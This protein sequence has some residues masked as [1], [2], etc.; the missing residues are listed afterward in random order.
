MIQRIGNI[1]LIII[2]LCATT[3]MVV[4]KHYMH[5]ELYSTAIFSN[6][7]SCCIDDTTCE[8]CHEENSKL[9]IDQSFRNSSQQ[10]L[11]KVYDQ[12]AQIIWNPTE[13]PVASF[14][15]EISFPPPPLRK[16]GVSLHTLMQVFLL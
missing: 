16:A 5:G 11:A 2:L 9:K 4:K 12:P 7:D 3:G 6:P 13:K 8:C 15:R 14:L 1:A 10:Q